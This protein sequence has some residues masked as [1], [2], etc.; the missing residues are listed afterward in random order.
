MSTS[1]IRRLALALLAAGLCASAGCSKL[2]CGEGTV[3]LDDKCISSVDPG[4]QC[5]PG[6]TFNMSTGRCESDLF[7]QGGGLCGENTTQIVDDAGVRVCQ[8]TGSGT[9][10]CSSPLPCPA[11]TTANSV[12][13]C[14]RVFDLEDSTPLDDGNAENGEPHKTIELRVLD[15]LAF[16]A[17][18]NATI[19]AK[20]TP[21]ACGRFAIPNAP[22]PPAGF[23]A[24]TTEDITNE[25]GQPAIGDNLVIAGVAFAVESGEVLPTIRAFIFKRS[26]D[27]AWST[28]AGLASGTTFGS[29]GVYVPIFLAPTSVVAP[30]PSSPTAD[31]M[32]TLNNASGIRTVKPENDFYFDDTMPLIRRTVSSTRAQTG[33]NGSALYINQPGLGNFSGIGNAPVGTCW[34]VN[35]AA[36]PKGGA[37][38]QERSA[39]SRFCP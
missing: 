34:A 5:A 2:E 11:P 10:N 36:A 3:E 17:N 16:I 24:V 15:P 9:G 21:D 29:L 22:R 38:V 39:E 31:V 8:G 4:A 13:L 18:P 37:F 12:S 20:A 28:A 1:E 32:V 25:Q 35:P 33:A 19:L 7:N 14:G 26:T 23:I 27:A 30:F 6:T